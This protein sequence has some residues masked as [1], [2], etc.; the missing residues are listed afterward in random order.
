MSD[1]PRGIRLFNPGNIR[2]SST[3]WLG[4]ITPSSDPDFEEFADVLYG[5]RAAG[6]IFCHYNL[7]EGLSSIA[8]YITRWAPP[9]DSNPT[10][11]YVN[12]VAKACNVDPQNTYNILAPDLLQQLLKAVFRFEQGSDEYVTDD[13]IAEGVK[14]A[15]TSL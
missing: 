6:K 11:G 7:H 9:S 15:L 5:I 8:Q 12:F 4:K 13:Q 3:K 1:L 14:E 10:T 2:I